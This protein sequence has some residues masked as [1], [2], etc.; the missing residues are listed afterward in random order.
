MVKDS[1]PPTLS[2]GYPAIAA[3]P[4]PNDRIIQLLISDRTEPEVAVAQVDYGFDAKYG[5]TAS[6]GPGYKRRLAVT[7]KNLQKN[8]LYHYRVTLTDPSGNVTVTND[9]MLNTSSRPKR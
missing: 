1:S 5:S 2:A 3:G 9:F 4:E 7:L 6:S 8:A